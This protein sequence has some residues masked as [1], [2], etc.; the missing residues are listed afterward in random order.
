M[1][2]EDVARDLRQGQEEH[3]DAQR[4][5]RVRNRLLD[6]SRAKERRTRWLGVALA[7]VVVATVIVVWAQRTPDAPLTF[8]VA[9]EP[10]THDAFVS[11]EDAALPLTFSD[12]SRVELAE[13]SRARVGNLS[14]RGASLRIEDGRA[15]VQVVHQ[16]ET[17]WEVKA[18]PY[19]VH[20]VGTRFA[21]EW[22]ARAASFRVEMAEGRVEI[23]GPDG[24][25]TVLE[26]TEALERDHP[27]ASTGDE[28]L[29]EESDEAPPAQA[30]EV[31][32]LVEEP[33]ANEALVPPPVTRLS[34]SRPAWRE[35]AEAG[36]YERARQALDARRLRALVTEGSADELEQAGNT[37]RRAQDSRSRDAWIALRDRFEGHPRGA[38][39][40]FQLARDAFQ[41]GELAEC[42]QWLETYLQEAP[43]GSWEMQAR[44]RLI[45]VQ[46][47]LERPSLESTVRSY[48][49]RF[50]DGPHA[51]FARSQLRH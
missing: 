34:P 50:P 19:T 8:A 27:A 31:V 26:G 51:R 25:H 11:A 5:L 38:G 39:A 43:R 6:E 3:L 37:L 4:R 42:E 16:D 20:V 49:A 1:S 22:D 18:G 44:G 21:V 17:D 40:A 33:A 10:G 14:A 41:R 29:V 23:D 12:G 24:F 45:E 2:L 28:A 30:P 15:D 48:L 47:A 13:G 32:E 46:A 35:L 36:D 9:G 7:A